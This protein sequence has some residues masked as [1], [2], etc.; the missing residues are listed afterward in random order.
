MSEN[1]SAFS[2]ISL[3]TFLF[4]LV[5]RSAAFITLCSDWCLLW[6][7]RLVFL[8][9]AETVVLAAE[10]PGP[11]T[12]KTYPTGCKPVAFSYS[13]ASLT[14]SPNAKR[15][16]SFPKI[17][18]CILKAIIYARSLALCCSETCSEGPVDDLGEFITPLCPV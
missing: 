9:P 5:C 10:R 2:F 4:I 11:P 18:S 16:K 14:T 17:F 1:M 7:S 3:N 15:W 13:T 8:H 6:K 12:L